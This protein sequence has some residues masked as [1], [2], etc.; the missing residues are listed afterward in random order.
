[1]WHCAWFRRSLTA[2]GMTVVAVSR[3]STENKMQDMEKPNRRNLYILLVAVALAWGLSWPLNKLGLDFIPPFW[4]AAFR[5]IFGTISMFLLVIYLKKL[6]I[7]TKQDLPLI[8]LIGIFQIGSFILF[9]NLGLVAQS[10]GTAAILVYTTPLWVMPM[11]IF[12]FKEPSMFLKWLGFALGLI[13][14]LFMLNPWEIDWRSGQILLSTFFLMSASLSC[15]ISILCAKYMT[16]HHSPLELIPWQLLVGCVMLTIV[17]LI[18]QPH[19]TLQ[20][21]ATSIICLAYTAVIATALGF[22][23]MTKLSKELPATVTS[24]GFLGVPVSG[25]IFSVILLHETLDLFKILAMLFIISGLIC[26]VWGGRKR[27]S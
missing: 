15:S 7:P 3:M 20:W 10:G 12:F 26:V 4:F 19:P 8:F 21:N 14:V 23:G 24:I 5:L 18:S 27:R 11:A 2:F 9:I 17:A 25:V 6:I 22:L 1:M 13:G 16:W